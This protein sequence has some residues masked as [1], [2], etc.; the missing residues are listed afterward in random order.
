MDPNDQNPNGGMPADDQ[1]TPM[2]GGDDANQPAAGGDTNPEP[3]APADAPAAD[4]PAGE[5]APAA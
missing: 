2:A 5:D 4:V 1:G 3:K